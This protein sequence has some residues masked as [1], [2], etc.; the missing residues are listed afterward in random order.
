MLCNYNDLLLSWTRVRKKVLDSDETRLSTAKC[1]IT[2]RRKWSSQKGNDKR[3][4]NRTYCNVSNRANDAISKERGE[5]QTYLTGMEMKKNSYA[6]SVSRRLLVSACR[7]FKHNKISAVQQIDVQFV[8]KGTDCMLHNNIISLLKIKICRFDKCIRLILA[9]LV[10][11]I[12]II[13]TTI[14]QEP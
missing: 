2:G 1:Y 11:K 4:V 10:R 6:V 13:T 5:G 9:T 3:A 14:R 7:T 12:I 8:K